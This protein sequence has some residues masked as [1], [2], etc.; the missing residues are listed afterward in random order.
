MTLSPKIIV[1]FKC[2]LLKGRRGKIPIK[3]AALLAVYAWVL[4]VFFEVGY[5]NSPPAANID[6]FN[7]RNLGWEKQNY[8]LNKLTPP[9]FLQYL[10]VG[11]KTPFGF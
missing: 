4:F 9:E 6:I 7:S 2:V 5:K 10:Q 11:Q 3:M 8:S 1:L